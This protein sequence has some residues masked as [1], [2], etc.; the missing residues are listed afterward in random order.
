MDSR[1]RP[2]SLSRLYSQNSRISWNGNPIPYSDL[3]SFLEK[4]PSSTTE[5]QAYDC[6]PIPATNAT[7][8]LAPAILITVTGQVSPFLAFF[9]PL[10]TF[11]I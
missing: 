10:L 4:L 1:E 2:G 11:R 9:L 3:I 6:H 8:E 5:V 7:P